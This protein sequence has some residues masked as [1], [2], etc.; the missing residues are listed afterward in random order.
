MSGLN[1]IE[2]SSLPRS[3][4]SHDYRRAY[5]DRIPMSQKERD[6]PQ[7]PARASCSGE[8]TQAEAARL[9]GLSP[10]PGAP[11][12]AQAA[13]QAAM[14]PSSMAC[15][16]SPP[17]AASTPRFAPAGPASLPPALCR[18]RPDLRQR[19]AGRARA[20]RSARRRCAAGCSPRDC[21]SASAAATRT[22]A[23]GR[24]AP[25]SASWCRWTPRSTTGWRAAARRWS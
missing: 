4:R 8:R 18:L 1:A 6:R 22:A 25:A 13:K 10:P 2:M 7:D 23:A 9:L 5:D 3:R 19:E 17:T 14:R 21:G 15:A 11:P 12:A 24:G 20:W 16:A